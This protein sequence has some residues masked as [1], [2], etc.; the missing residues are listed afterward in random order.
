ME[1]QACSEADA[2]YIVLDR[3]AS[4]FGQVPK[5]KDLTKSSNPLFAKL[6]VSQFTIGEGGC[7]VSI[8][9]GFT[10]AEIRELVHEYQLQPHGQ[11][12]IWLRERGLTYE[13]L[14]KWR[15]AVFGGNL[16]RGLVPR[17]ARGMTLPPRQRTELEKQRAAERAAQKAETERLQ[18][19]IRELEETNAAL[20]KAIGLLH[21]MSEQEPGEPQPKT[22]RSS[23]SMPSTPSSQN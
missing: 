1:A 4:S 8:T 14:I 12:A 13:R 3:S 23:S 21:Q 19:R 16:D 17:Q 11:K 15:K 22:D 18:A 20:G 10:A 2:T 9:P 5:L 7:R 6:V